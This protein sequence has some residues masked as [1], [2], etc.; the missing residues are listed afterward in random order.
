MMRSTSRSAAAETAS[1]MTS[2]PSSTCVKPAERMLDIGVGSFSQ[3]WRALTTSPSFIA[4]R[5]LLTSA[6]G[7]IL[8]GRTRMPQSMAR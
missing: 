5:T 7:M 8:E 2:K 6:A 1:W 3:N 4:S